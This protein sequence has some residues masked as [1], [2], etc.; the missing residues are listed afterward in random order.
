MTT[1]PDAA[2][3]AA[4]RDVLAGLG[5]PDPSKEQL[6]EAIETLRRFDPEYR[7]LAP[8]GAA[9]LP[10]PQAEGDVREALYGL[11]CDYV[12][13]AFGWA[14]GW[15]D[16]P[17]GVRMVFQAFAD[18]VLS[19]GLVVPV[20]EV[21]RGCGKTYTQ[22]Y[23]AG[24]VI[25][26]CDRDVPHERCATRVGETDQVH[27][28]RLPARLLSGVHVG[29]EVVLPDGTRGRLSEVLSIITGA[30]VLLDAVDTKHLDRDD[31]VTLVD[32]DAQ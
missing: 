19:S 10:A 32:G 21:E 4:A 31:V 23:E 16:A 12:A 13:P 14:G 22:H 30:I 15:H 18:A 9:A 11:L 26:T 8:L 6:D 5:N 20:G 27:P 25:W 1:I 28:E 29:R 7:N 24:D 3:E 2:I 17:P